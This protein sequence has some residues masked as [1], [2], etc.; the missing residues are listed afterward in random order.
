MDIKLIVFDLNGVFF[1]RVK[2]KDADPNDDRK[3]YDYGW[4]RY[5]IK[6]G[7]YKFINKYSKTYDMG[8][9]TSMTHDNVHNI[10]KKM[11]GCKYKYKFKFILTREHVKFDP[12]YGL[13]PEIESYDTVKHLDD[14]FMN[15][16]CNKYRKYNPDNTII[17]DDSYKKIRFNDPKNVIILNSNINESNHGYTVCSSYK[18]IS[19]L[20]EKSLKNKKY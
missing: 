20:L 6:E 16:M 11:F 4:M 9:Y 15:P 13:L 5:Y 1:D 12:E 19:E 2:L 18:D 10:L 17:I 7:I 8:I 3:Y 14:I